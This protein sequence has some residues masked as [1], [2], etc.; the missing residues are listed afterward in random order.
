MDCSM[1]GSS[2]HGIFQ[3]RILEWVSCS[4]SRGSSWPRDWNQVSC[5]AGRLFTVWATRESL[6]KE[7]LWLFPFLMKESRVQRCSVGCPSSYLQ[8][9]AMWA[10]FNLVLFPYIQNIKTWSSLGHWVWWGRAEVLVV[11]SSIQVRALSPT[12]WENLGKPLGTLAVGDGQGGLACG[13]W[14]RKE[15]DMTERLN[16]TKLGA[17]FLFTCDDFFIRFLWNVRHNFMRNKI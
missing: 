17:Q 7:R 3:E 13:S 6:C 15:S 11:E 14:D 5:I 2:L 8:G 12:S 1:P 9:I 4:F 10:F 16:W